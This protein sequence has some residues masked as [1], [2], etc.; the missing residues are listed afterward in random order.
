MKLTCPNC[1]TDSEGNICG[2][3]N[4]DSIEIPI[5]IERP[6]EK[7]RRE[8]KQELERLQRFKKR[9]SNI[10]TKIKKESQIL[11][12]CDECKLPKILDNIIEKI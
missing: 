1:G 5:E 2:I 8:L 9:V 10:I 6:S 7:E 3:C 4:P 12:I 11:Q